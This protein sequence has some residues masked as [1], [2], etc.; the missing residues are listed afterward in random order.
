MCFYFDCV[1]NLS[2]SER[3]R[4]RV[5][6]CVILVQISKL[7]RAARNREAYTVR[8]AAEGASR[9]ALDYGAVIN[10]IS[11]HFMVIIHVCPRSV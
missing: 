2:T 8:G 10:L 6:V 9:A 7:P 3:A 1:H 4:A 5:C 11:T